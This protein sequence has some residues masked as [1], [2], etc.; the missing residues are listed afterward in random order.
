MLETEITYAH[1]VKC[2]FESKISAMKGVGDSVCENA[3]EM[4]IVKNIL[5]TF[6]MMLAPT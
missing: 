2:L 3:G 1:F 4:Y 5:P 6:V